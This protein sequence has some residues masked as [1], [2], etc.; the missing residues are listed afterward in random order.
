MTEIWSGSCAC[1]A[2][3]YEASA[4]PVNPH[5][6]HCLACR[7]SVGAPVVAWV[8]FPLAQFR[9]RRGVPTYYA[10]SSAMR[11]GFCERCGTSLCTEEDDGY[12]CVTIA[13]LDQ[14]AELA[15]EYHIYAQHAL[16]WLRLADGLP[17]E[18]RDDRPR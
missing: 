5:Y 10:S 18:A 2:V 6:C 7:R 17:R 12:I 8:N 3:Q 4:A 15:P 9:W 11:R 13:S 16:E 14:A 1:G